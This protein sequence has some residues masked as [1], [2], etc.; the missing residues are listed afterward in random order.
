MLF[1]YGDSHANDCFKNLKIPYKNLH[2]SNKTMYRVGRDRHIINFNRN[3]H[4][5]DSI[6]ILVYGEIDCRCQIQKQ[7]NLGQ[8]KDFVINSLVSNYFEAIISNVDKYKHIIIVAIIPPTSQIDYE[9]NNGPITHEYPFVG[10]D[11]NR[12]MYTKEVNKLLEIF[13]KQYN[14]T[15][16]NPYEYYTRQDG[17]LKYEFSDKTVH[18]KDTSYFHEQFYKLLS[19][20]GT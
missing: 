4:T 9:S 7:I 13:C 18:L 15:F 14:Y 1:I 19:D 8:D 12:A 17:C 5:M 6:I 16:F 10:T 11:E 20:L 3:H 2:L